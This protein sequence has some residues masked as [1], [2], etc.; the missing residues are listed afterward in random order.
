M[1]IKQTII[2]HKGDMELGDLRG[3]LPVGMNDDRSMM[4]SGMETSFGTISMKTR[5]A[6][7]CDGCHGGGGPCGL[8]SLCCLRIT[9]S[10]SQSSQSYS[11]GQSLNEITPA[12]IQ[13]HRFSFFS[14]GRL[15]PVDVLC[16][17]YPNL[18]AC[19]FGAT[20]LLI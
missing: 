9:M 5:T 17:I 1:R 10:N 20:Q 6:G 4:V 3:L 11:R 19:G 13:I 18:R 7:S 14:G 8:L 15:P 16:F 2:I 12:V